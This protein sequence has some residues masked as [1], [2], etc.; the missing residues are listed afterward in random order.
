MIYIFI[1][2][3]CSLSVICY[4]HDNSIPMAKDKEK[5]IV[6]FLHKKIPRPIKPQTQYSTFSDYI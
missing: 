1:A 4:F 6:D 2:N 3:Y 5:V